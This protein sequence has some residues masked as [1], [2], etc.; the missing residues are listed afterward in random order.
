MLRP[1]FGQSGD[2]GAGLGD[3]GEVT[4]G[5]HVGRKASVEPDGGDHHAEAVGADKPQAVR[6]RGLLRGVGERVGAVTQS[7]GDNDRRRGALRTRRRDYR[8]RVDSEFIPNVSYVSL[9][10]GTGSGARGRLA[11]KLVVSFDSL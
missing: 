9:G 4:S 11:F 10:F 1:P 8:K 6:P 7:R 5:R 2:D 3:Q